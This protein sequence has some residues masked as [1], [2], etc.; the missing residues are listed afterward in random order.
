[1]DLLKKQLAWLRGRNAEKA[2]ITDVIGTVSGVGLADGKAKGGRVVGILGDTDLYT[3]PAGKV[4]F[5]IAWFRNNPTGGAITT[6]ANII[7]GALSI[8]LNGSAGSVG[9][10][11]ANN[12]PGTVA[13]LMSEGEI[14]RVNDSAAGLVHSW[15]LVEGPAGPNAFLKVARSF[16]ITTVAEKIYE[17]P[18]GKYGVVLSA[19]I[20][21]GS[22]AVTFFNNSG[23][24]AKTCSLYLVP[25]G[26]SV[27]AEY[28]IGTSSPADNGNAGAISS[29]PVIPPGY[30]L[31]VTS[32][33]N[34]AGVK[35]RGMV[36]EYDA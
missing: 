15:S 29:I 10:G 32:S 31:W 7:S 11:V 27:A 14:L 34:D 28:L 17:A 4:A 21:A 1:M 23:T 30:G 16:E 18:A 9:A 20:A 36:A 3:V 26:Q 22:A 8:R 35:C 12:I 6:V 19:P 25:P 33:S 24:G 2:G 13:S 5:V